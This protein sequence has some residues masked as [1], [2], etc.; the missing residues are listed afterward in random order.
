[1]FLTLYML[2]DA[3]PNCLNSV[4]VQA[5]SWPFYHHNAS[6]CKLSLSMLC[7]M[8]WCIIFLKNKLSVDVNFVVYH[9][10]NV[11]CERFGRNPSPF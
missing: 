4:K 2:F 11:L 6:L 9:R 3:L 10:N 1:M 5:T 7:C 8:N